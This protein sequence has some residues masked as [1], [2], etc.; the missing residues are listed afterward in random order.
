MRRGEQAS[1]PL[2][3]TLEAPFSG[4]Q[5]PLTTLLS[6]LTHVTGSDSTPNSRAVTW[7]PDQG[8]S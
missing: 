1:L 6:V 3:H 2:P 7:D 5:C 4:T 8:K